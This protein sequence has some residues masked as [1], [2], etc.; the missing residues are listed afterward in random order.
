MPYLE[1]KN[2]TGP[3]LKTLVTCK[4]QFCPATSLAII[5]V[6]L[7]LLY[8]VCTNISSSLASAQALPKG[9][10][11]IYSQMSLFLLATAIWQASSYGGGEYIIP[12]TSQNPYT[13][14]SFL[15]A[16]MQN[17]WHSPI[18]NFFQSNISV[19]YK[20]KYLYHFFKCGVCI[21]KMTMGGVH[22]YQDLTHHN[23]KGEQT[24]YF[25]NF[26]TPF[27]VN[28]TPM[29]CEFHTRQVV[30]HADDTNYL[31]N[32]NSLH[33]YKMIAAALPENLCKS[34]FRINDI[35]ALCANASAQVG[36]K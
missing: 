16:K 22:C 34:S 10:H 32:I 9:T 28:F 26:F 35:P 33:H 31:M 14:S 13:N 30:M 6:F 3:D 1:A 27:N 7:L 36:K 21:C 19:G 12:A 11:P 18:Y 17:G 4:P 29:S 23:H 24:V 25:T 15:P 2:R 8:Y 20:G 5:V